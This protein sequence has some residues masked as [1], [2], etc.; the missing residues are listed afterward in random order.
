[1]ARTVSNMRLLH[2]RGVG[3]A[4]KQAIEADA[5]LKKKRDALKKAGK[6]TNSAKAAVVSKLVRWMWLIGLQVQHER[7]SAERPQPKAI[8]SGAEGLR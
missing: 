5:R 3:S 8:P 4:R 7:A 2:A 6:H 1:M